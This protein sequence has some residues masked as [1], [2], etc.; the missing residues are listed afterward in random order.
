MKTN[1][2]INRYLMAEMV[3]PFVITLTFFTFIFLMTQILEIT[4]LVVNFNVSMLSIGLMLA[5]TMPFF[6]TFII[7]MSVMMAVLLTFLRMS[8]DN[9]ITALKAGGVSVYRLLPP[10]LLFCLLAGLLTGF[11]TI[12]G[13]PKG[14]LALKKLVYDVAV[15]NLDI[16]LKARTFNDS[17][18]GVM[19]YVNHIDQR[20][21]ELRDVFIEDQRSQGVVTTVVAP[22]GKIFSDP[23]A[24]AYQLR[25][26][27]GTIN[28]VDLEHRSAHAIRFDTY[29]LNLNLSRTITPDT[30][31]PKDE[32]EMGLRE[33]RDYLQ[34]ATQ[35][36]ARFYQALMEWHKKFSL[37]FA[38]LALGVLAVPLG[39]QSQASRKS[40]GVG[41]GLIFFLMYYL[42]LST[43]WVF[44]EA[45]VYPPVIGMWLPNVVMG[46][47]G[48]FLLV[49]TARE[50]PVI[51]DGV[52]RLV[53]RVKRRPSNHEPRA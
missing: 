5:Y 39:I 13:L 14:R 12:Y 50:R 1:T 48:L 22:Q 43:G 7:P 18:R 53:T 11:M 52:R 37:P 45:G 32:E 3:P 35:K 47:I 17:F 29:D 25:L 10:V 27:N 4:H 36:D 31:G 26:F 41:L 46:G 51:P 38:C 42:M 9:E 20:T 15:S 8:G 6:L 40:F 24:L 30:D 34:A 21:K 44:G 28:Q 49:R 2:I 33:L 19:L 23:N 16:G